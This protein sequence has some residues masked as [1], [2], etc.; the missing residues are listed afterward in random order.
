[1]KRAICHPDRKHC[2]HGR[3]RECWQ[4]N[5]D[6]WR[7]YTLTVDEYETLYHQQQ[8][9]CK[10]CGLPE[11]TK[12]FKWLSVDHNHTTNTIRGLLCAHCNRGIGSFQE[13]IQLLQKAIEYL[14]R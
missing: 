4:R 13:D 10:I 9:L 2:C 12:R 3:C 11:M 7:N 5:R 1:M 6:L 14:N 8:G